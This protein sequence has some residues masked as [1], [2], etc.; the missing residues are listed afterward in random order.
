MSVSGIVSHIYRPIPDEWLPSLIKPGI[1]EP[2]FTGLVLCGAP[3]VRDLF[4][5][6]VKSPQALSPAT[7]ASVTTKRTLQWIRHSHGVLRWLELSHAR[8][9]A[10]QVLI[11]QH[12]PTTPFIAVLFTCFCLSL[13]NKHRAE[14]LRRFIL[15]AYIAYIQLIGRRIQ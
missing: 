7:G 3:R 13:E 10:R 1:N 8:T 2:L 15:Y 5:A 4:R 6:I 9:A 11:G 12:C 14:P